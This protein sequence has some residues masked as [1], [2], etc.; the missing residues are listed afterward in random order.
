MFEM[1]YSTCNMGYLTRLFPNM[2]RCVLLRGCCVLHE[3][4]CARGVKVR[5]MLPLYQG[6]HMTFSVPLSLKVLS[7]DT[8]LL[9]TTQGVM[10]WCDVKKDTTSPFGPPYEVLLPYARHITAFY[11]TH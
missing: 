10:V 2:P 3:K 1:K 5:C 11:N 9:C 6:P 7:A 4:V 8:L